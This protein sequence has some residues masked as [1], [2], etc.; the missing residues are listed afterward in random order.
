VL[1]IDLRIAPTLEAPGAARIAIEGVRGGLM[2]RLP[3]ET[4]VDLYADLRL[5]VS[6]LVSNSVRHA[7][8]AADQPVRLTLRIE[9]STLRVEV[10]DKG[11]GLRDRPLDGD[12]LAATGG[13]GLLLVERLTDR[14]GA[15]QD[16]SSVVWFEID[17]GGRAR[18][19]GFAPDGP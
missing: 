16:G 18:P 17:L 7:G 12:P 15:S 4:A 5:L 13:R 3:H 9:R 10:H 1:D 2:Q 19:D 8:L 11:P 6:E 14:W